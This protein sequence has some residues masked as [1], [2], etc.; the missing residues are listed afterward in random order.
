MKKFQLI[1][2]CGLIA[3]SV[4]DFGENLTQSE[5]LELICTMNVTKRSIN[6]QME[7]FFSSLQAKELTWLKKTEDR[8]NFR[9]MCKRIQLKIV[10]FQVKM[11]QELH[12][13][14]RN[15]TLVEYEAYTKIT[16]RLSGFICNLD[17]R[18]L[19]ILGKIENYESIMSRGNRILNCA[20]NSSNNTESDFAT[21]FCTINDT[22][23]FDCSF[24]VFADNVEPRTLLKTIWKFLRSLITC[25]SSG[26][27]RKT[28]IDAKYVYNY[29][30]NLLIPTIQ[31]ILRDSNLLA[32]ASAED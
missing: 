19:K 12:E 15:E 14:L 27:E 5:E 25:E 18:R 7:V 20:R 29:F 9:R 11:I 26:A 31:G 10:A 1:I 4:G 6:P 32:E 30:N 13:C 8:V 21:E 22:I 3:L 16:N 2:F 23:L 28:K 24:S 17:E